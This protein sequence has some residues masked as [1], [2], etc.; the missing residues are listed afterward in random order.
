MKK[1]LSNHKRLKHGDVKQYNCEHCVYSTLN[2]THLENHVRSQ[3]L[4]V[5]EVCESCSKEFSDKSHLNRHVRQ[6]HSETVQEKR[7]ATE[8][9]ETPS[10]KINIMSLHAPIVTRNSR[11]YKIKTTIVRM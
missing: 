8:T 1:S 7:K 10:K 4:K 2:K 11:N 3:H 5:K 6:F 9:L